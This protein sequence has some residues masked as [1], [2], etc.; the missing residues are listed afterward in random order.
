[1]RWHEMRQTET[2]G[3]RGSPKQC[4]GSAMQRGKREG[5]ESEEVRERPGHDDAN[6][7]AAAPLGSPRK[8]P[9]SAAAYPAS[10]G[11]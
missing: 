6:M 10:V 7:V 11:L 9:R 4:S 8:A 5:D 1:M 2:P 3:P